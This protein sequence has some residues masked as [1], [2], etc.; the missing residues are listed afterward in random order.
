[1]RRCDGHRMA[2]ALRRPA[3][4]RTAV[5]A[6]AALVAAVAPR[7]APAQEPVC[8]PDWSAVAT[9]FFPLAPLGPAQPIL[10][11]FDVSDAQANFVADPFL[12]QAGGLWYLFFEAT[13][14]RGVVALATSADLMTWH[15]EHIVLA[16]PF[17]MSFPHVF[18]VDGSYYMTPESAVRNSVRLYRAKRFPEE[19]EYL[20][21]LITGR[22]YADPAVFRR[23]GRWWMFVSSA[24]CSAGYLFS[25]DSLTCGWTEHPMSPIIANNRGRARAAG[26]AVQLAGGRL[27]RVA[28]NDT[29]TYGRTTRVFEVDVL[30]PAD[31]HEGEVPESPIL[32]A[33]GFGWN[34]TG[35]HTCDPWWV[36]DHWV[37]AVDG[38]TGS[39]G[40]SIGLYGTPSPPPPEPTDAPARA[41]S[42]PRLSCGP[43]PSPGAIVFTLETPGGAADNPA[44]LR[45][46]DAAGRLVLARTLPV[47]AAGRTQFEWNGRNRN[48]R[49]VPAGE[50][51][52]RVE[53]QSQTAQTRAVLTR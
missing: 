3:V 27:F 48:G 22:P 32:A 35:M 10:T 19:W 30:T 25:S 36:G 31:Y 47:P 14:P 29:P 52:C 43:N 51:F 50:Y 45:I 42:A 23:D 21:D 38:L 12:I 40:W 39:A 53:Y 20:G 24:D 9:P 17:H 33:S 7:P 37:A 41:T 6:I 2:A 11:R 15:Y 28:Q 13:I 34:A 49:R 44:T 8:R 1:M 16:E 5:G 26:R 46:V 18:E 4:R